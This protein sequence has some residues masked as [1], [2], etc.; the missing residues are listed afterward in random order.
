MS[1]GPQG[2]RPQER[3]P[4]K[5]SCIMC[6]STAFDRQRMGL[7]LNATSR[8]GICKECYLSAEQ[9]QRNQG[10]MRT[11]RIQDVSRRGQRNNVQNQP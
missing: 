3:R 9:C 5:A 6:S 10:H 1:P 2:P 7:K 8:L 4:P 11:Q